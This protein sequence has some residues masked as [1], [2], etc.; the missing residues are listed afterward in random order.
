MNG[1]L[2]I[3]YSSDDNYIRHAGVSILSVLENNKHFETIDIYIIDNNVSRENKVKLNEIINQYNRNIK[4]ID[5]SEYKSKLKLNMGWKISIS[6]YARLFVDEM[7]PSDLD[8]VLYFDCDTIVIGELDELWSIELNE[9]EYIAGVIDTVSENNVKSIEMN[10]KYSYINSGMLLI[11][12]K[13]WREKEIKQQFIEFIDKY[14]GSVNHHDQGVLNGVL[15]TKC[16]IISPK[17]NMMSV[18]LMMKY[19]DLYDYYDMKY[20]FYSKSELEQAK[21]TPI[22]I[23]FTP[24]F[25][26]RPWVK[27]CKHP[28]KETYLKYL[29]QTPWKNY[30]LEQDRSRLRVKIINYLY[31]NFPIKIVNTLVNSALQIKNR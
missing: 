2:T 26:T 20:K 7:L 11:N 25:T 10:K 27:G 21:D 17:F 29:R 14:D 13:M 5:F 24:G 1:N 15:H 12:L 28:Y 16:K 31:R 22:Y 9:N 30:E 4:Y 8:K 3:V 23:H 6:A 18:Y 19:E